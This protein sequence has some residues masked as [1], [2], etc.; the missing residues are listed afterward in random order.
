MFDKF[1]DTYGLSADSL[2]YNHNHPPAGFHFAVVFMGSPFRGDMMFQE[3]SGLSCS[4]TDTI[5]LEEG[6]VPY[7]HQLPSLKYKYDDLVLKRGLTALSPVSN[8]WIRGALNEL[9]KPTS[10]LISLLNENRQPMYSWHVVGAYPVAWSFSPLDATKGEVMIET[11]TL[12]YQYFSV[13][14]TIIADAA[15][16]TISGFI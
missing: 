13:Y 11:I 8:L 9:V 6:G 15:T 12:K 10:I 3:I 5:P 7:T 2:D 14:D 1:L 4:T 16:D